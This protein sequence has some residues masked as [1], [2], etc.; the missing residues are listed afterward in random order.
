MLAR[1]RRPQSIIALIC[2][3]IGLG[4]VLLYGWRA[5]R[6]F[7]HVREGPR[8]TDVELIHDWMTVHYL[9]RVYQVPPDYIF[10]ELGIPEAENRHK[11]IQQLNEELAPDEPGLILDQVKAIVLQFQAE[12]TPPE[13]PH[14]PGPPDSSPPER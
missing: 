5:L 12:H 10:D 4:L 2:I 14:P 9:S 11:S 8:E 7:R 1:L 6:A 3:L 13:P